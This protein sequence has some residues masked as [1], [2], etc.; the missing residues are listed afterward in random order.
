VDGLK[1]LTTGDIED[2]PVGLA[3]LAQMLIVVE[4]RT[5]I[6]ITSHT[7]SSPSLLLSFIKRTGGLRLRLCHLA[8][9]Q[10]QNAEKPM[11]VSNATFTSL[12]TTSQWNAIQATH[13]IMR[14]RL[15]PSPTSPSSSLPASLALHLP[16]SV[17]RPGPPFVIIL[18]S[19]SMHVTRAT[20]HVMLAQIA[21]IYVRCE[22]Y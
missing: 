17:P 1:S 9:K 10:A 3:E 18:C 19:V 20:P 12:Y 11:G 6:H 15:T 21:K 2:A 16:V 7:P 13:P 14:A 22:I 5:H 4:V 8:R